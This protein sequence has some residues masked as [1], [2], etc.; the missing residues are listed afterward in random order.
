M[1]EPKEKNKAGA[2]AGY[3]YKTDIWTRDSVWKQ[4]SKRGKNSFYA[5]V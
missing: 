1:T 3:C 2:Q 4:L 5:Y